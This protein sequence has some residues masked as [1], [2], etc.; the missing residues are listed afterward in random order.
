MRIICDTASLFKPE[1]E[2]KYGIR[3]L[4]LNVTINN[5][6]YQELKEIDLKTFIQKIYDGG[7]P[8]S[9]QPSV[10]IVMEVF[11]ESDEEILA[12]TMADG[13]SGTYQTFEGVAQSMERDNIHVLN[14]RTLCGPEYLLV[15]KAIRLKNEGRN[16]NEILDELNYSM[17][18][19]ASFLIPSDFEFL[20]RGGRLS[21]LAATLGGFMKIV[22]VLK[23][24]DDGKI[25]EKFAIK[26][27]FKGAVNDII[28][29]FHNMNIDKD[30]TVYVTHADALDKADMAKNLIKESFPDTTIEIKELTPVF[31][32][33]GG[34]GCVA[35]Q[36]IHN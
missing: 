33:Q 13:L 3:V 12:I 10:G 23:E 21:P 30:Y 19:H 32:T 25:L 11:E 36:V 8:S 7:I 18:H 2:V 14:S 6:T 27:T 26:K 1:D 9:S 16:L 4:P 15:H 24:S 17:D 28:Q 35:I 29:Y 22:P 20:K 31:T 34:P 5:E